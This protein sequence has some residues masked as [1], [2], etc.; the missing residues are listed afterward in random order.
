MCGLG[1][2]L[3]IKNDHLIAINQPTNELTSCLTTN[4]IKRLKILK[5]REW[6]IWTV[7]ISHQVNDSGL[8]RMTP[9]LNPLKSVTCLF[10]SRIMANRC[11]VCVCVC[12]CFCACACAYCICG[13]CFHR[14]RCAPSAIVRS[15]VILIGS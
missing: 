6:D 2:F 10:V 14:S 7:L 4:V 15:S 9:S 1:L 3:I 12:V 11:I 8:L 5:G 13:C